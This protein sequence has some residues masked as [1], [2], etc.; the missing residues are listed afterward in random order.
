MWQG[1]VTGWKVSLRVSERNTTGYGGWGSGRG[2]GMQGEER[3]AIR[4]NT[5]W[6]GKGS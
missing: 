4:E 5:D 2:A 1:S 6:N 3:K